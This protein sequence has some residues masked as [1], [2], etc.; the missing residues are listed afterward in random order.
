[1]LN[2]GQNCCSSVVGSDGLG[3]FRRGGLGAAP[4]LNHETLPIF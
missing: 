3:R 1:M 2:M 4:L